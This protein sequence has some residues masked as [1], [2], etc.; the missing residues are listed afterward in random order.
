MTGN[1]TNQRMSWEDQVEHDL[2]MLNQQQH[3]ETKSR[4]RDFVGDCIGVIAIATIFV[5]FLLVT[6]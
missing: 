2:K 4:I 6:I 1:Q 3:L 5:A